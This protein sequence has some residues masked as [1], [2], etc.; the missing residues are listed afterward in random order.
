MCQ[1]I[2][3]EKMSR[4]ESLRDR[5]SVV[6]TSS[7]DL[8]LATPGGTEQQNQQRCENLESRDDAP[9]AASTTGVPLGSRAD[10]PLWSRA[11]SPRLRSARADPSRGTLTEF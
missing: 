8:R 3:V 6:T 2:S 4:S 1:H 9:S 10:Q 7:A 5:G 11:A